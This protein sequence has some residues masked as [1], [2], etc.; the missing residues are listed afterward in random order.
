MI[1]L[2][3]TYVNGLIIKKDPY[4]KSSENIKPFLDK[5]A[6]AT[7]IT[8]LV[9]VLNSLKRNNFNGNVKGIVNQL[10]NVHIFDF[11]S[12]EDYKKA[13]ELFRFY[14]HAIN[15]ADCTILVSMQKHGITRIATFDSDFDKIHW[16]NRICGFF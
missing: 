4:K 2:D 16:I 7:N 11:L 10:F 3:T 1:F 6:K 5:E 13:M 12:K 15:F 8:V 14:N 9:E